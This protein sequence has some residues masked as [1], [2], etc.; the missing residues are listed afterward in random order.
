M[1]NIHFSLEP[2]DG[3]GV[4]GPSASGKS[5]LARLLVGLN[6]PDKGSVR[7]D[8]ARY[9]QW[10]R[11]AIGRYLGYLPQSVGLMAGSIRQNIA[12]F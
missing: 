1:Q 4:I 9:D 10:D 7:L 5:S 6:M 3:L 11:D 2:G 8:G 12:P